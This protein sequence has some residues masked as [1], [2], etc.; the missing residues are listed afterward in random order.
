MRT[1]TQQEAERLNY[2]PLTMP[3]RKGSEDWITASIMDGLAGTRSA[4][5]HV[6]EHWVEVWRHDHELDLVRKAA[7]LENQGR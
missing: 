4:V 1:I 2:R 6:S 5:V 3:I 7:D